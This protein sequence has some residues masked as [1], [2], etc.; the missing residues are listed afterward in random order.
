MARPR[1]AEDA[2]PVQ[3]S[4]AEAS[5]GDPATALAQQT[6]LVERTA[7]RSDASKPPAKQSIG[8][9]PTAHQSIG[10]QSRDQQTNVSALPAQQTNALQPRLDGSPVCACF[11]ARRRCSTGL[12]CLFQSDPTGT[13]SYSHERPPNSTLDPQSQRQ[14]QPPPA[15]QVDLSGRDK[16]RPSLSLPRG[17]SSS[18]PPNAGR[19]RQLPPPRSTRLSLPRS[20]ASPLQPDVP[21]TASRNPS[22]PLPVA[23]ARGSVAVSPPLPA[24]AYST[25][26][27]VL[28]RIPPLLSSG[29]GNLKSDP[30]HST[31]LLAHMVATLLVLTA[32]PGLLFSSPSLIRYIMY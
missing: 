6:N 15:Y 4:A 9:E 13:S 19:F 1:T 11:N 8:P 31:L 24:G 10:L 28:W 18:P 5:G 29:D 20:A 22:P 27:R 26:A 3:M 32:L 17:S 23:R 16:S 25:P 14:S 30:H 21:L 2:P 7:K 12:L